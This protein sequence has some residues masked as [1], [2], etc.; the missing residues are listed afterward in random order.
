MIAPNMCRVR[1]LAFTGHDTAEKI[2]LLGG[3]TPSHFGVS[4]NPK[5]ESPAPESSPRHQKIEIAALI[6]LPSFIGQ[7]E[8]DIIRPQWIPTYHFREQQFDP[9]AFLFRGHHPL[10]TAVTPQETWS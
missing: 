3:R 1:G 4:Q 10:K 7:M 8:V 5:N 9:H 2:E 6:G